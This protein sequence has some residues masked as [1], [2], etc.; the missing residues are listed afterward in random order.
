MSSE[1][2]SGILTK[3]K[4]DDIRLDTTTPFHST[5]SLRPPYFNEQ[6]LQILS[7]NIDGINESSRTSKLIASAPRLEHVPLL[8]K[9]FSL[10]SQDG[11][12]PIELLDAPKVSRFDDIPNSKDNRAVEVTSRDRMALFW[13]SLDAEEGG[14]STGSVPLMDFGEALALASLRPRKLRKRRSSFYPDQRFSTFSTTSLHNKLPKKAPFKSRPPLPKDQVILDLPAGVEQVGSGIGYT[15]CV[16]AASHS[17]VSICTTTPQTCKSFFRLPAFGF[18]G[19]AA[20]SGLLWRTGKKSRSKQGL[21]SLSPGIG[22]KEHTIYLQDVFGSST[23]WSLG[24]PLSPTAVDCLGTIPME[25][26]ASASNGSSPISVSET[27]PLTPETLLFVE[28]QE[29]DADINAGAYRKHTSVAFDDCYRGEDGP[30][31]TV[32]E[33]DEHRSVRTLRLVSSEPSVLQLGS[34]N[35]VEGFGF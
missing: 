12:P 19:R 3:V 1:S 8:P 29:T 21:G 32:K 15:Y 23:A 16:P 24:S 17:K 35:S 9:L 26:L 25:I 22:R 33:H 18:L 10:P 13:D 27:G 6:D 31:E 20:D 30:G 7:Q 14:P 11:V 2:V 28:E 34:V 4:G 5:V